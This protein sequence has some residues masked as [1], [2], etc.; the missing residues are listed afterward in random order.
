MSRQNATWIIAGEKGSFTNAQSDTSRSIFSFS[1]GCGNPISDADLKKAASV[2]GEN[3]DRPEGNWTTCFDDL[4]KGKK[5]LNC[6]I[7]SDDL[8]SKLFSS[9]QC[10]LNSIGDNDRDVIYCPDGYTSKGYIYEKNY[11]FKTNN[12]YKICKRDYDSG[13]QVD[14]CSDKNQSY[15]INKCEEGYTYGT[16]KCNIRMKLHCDGTDNNIKESDHCKKWCNDGNGNDLN[17]CVDGYKKFCDDPKNRTTDFCMEVCRKAADTS[18]D[19]IYNRNKELRAMCER[20]MLSYCEKDPKK[21]FGPNTEESKFCKPFCEDKK[22]GTDSKGKCDTMITNYCVSEGADATYCRCIN[23]PAEYDKYLK[24]PG[25]NGIHCIDGTCKSKG[26]KTRM[27]EDS[28]CPPCIQTATAMENVNSKFTVN[29]KMECNINGIPVATDKPTPPDLP[30]PPTSG[31]TKTTSSGGTK[32]TSSGNGVVTSS[33]QTSKETTSS[34]TKTTS[35][36]T[37]TTSSGSDI[38]QSFFDNVDNTTFIVAMVILAFSILV[39]MYNFFG[40]SS[41][42]KNTTNRVRNRFRSRNN[43][44][45]DRRDN[46]RDNDYR[47]NDYRDN[48]Y[49]DNDYRDNDYRDNDYR[50]NDYR[51]SRGDYK[52]NRRDNDYRSP[53]DTD[54]KLI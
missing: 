29:Q 14:C 15:D 35:S 46:N 42:R 20:S 37:K 9:G 28:E 18:K 38:S 3:M 43:D 2:S 10:N 36:G 33:E 21:S 17:G 23:P 7:M 52:D 22:R 12:N 1:P 31:G 13:K 27:M 53:R 47:D 8:E 25:V 48:D 54:K 34:G 32:T 6:V 45:T 51:S 30:T 5:D 39:F 4:N 50:D 16:S 49:R 40:T 44:R 26:Y 24:A 41:R 11:G 19:S